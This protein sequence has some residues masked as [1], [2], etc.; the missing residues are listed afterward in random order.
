LPPF[1]Q[2]HK[3]ALELLGWLFLRNDQIVKARKLFEALARL[4]PGDVRMLR[5]LAYACLLSGDHGRA[6]ELCA[7]AIALSGDSVEPGVFLVRARALH[8][9]GRREETR[10]AVQ[11]FITLRSHT[12]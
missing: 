1:D 9:L 6:L 10:E 12:A 11:R 5:S 8:A 3:Q 7:E 2:T 4:S